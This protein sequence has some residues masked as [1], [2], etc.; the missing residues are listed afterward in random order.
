MT[1][2]FGQND[3]M[4]AVSLLDQGRVRMRG[5]HPP[6]FEAPVTSIDGVSAC[7][8]I[9]QETMLT[10]LRN[11]DGGEPR[12]VPYE[13]YGRSS[14]PLWEDEFRDSPS[15]PARRGRGARRCSHADVVCSGTKNQVLEAAHRQS[16]Q[17]ESIFVS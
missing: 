11:V 2:K 17:I 6:R 1:W 14:E 7:G 12:C 10:G 3:G 15:H 4:T 8:L 16:Q 13:L 9:S 5:P